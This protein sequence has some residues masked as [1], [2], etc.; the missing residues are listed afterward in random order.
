MKNVLKFVQLAFLAV[1]LGSFFLFVASV[2]SGCGDTEHFYTVKGESGV[3]GTNGA[4]GTNGING[5]QGPTGPINTSLIPILTSMP[6]NPQPGDEWFLY[7]PGHDFT[8]LSGTSS[9]DGGT[10][11]ITITVDAANAPTNNSIV[12]QKNCDGVINGIDYCANT[13]ISTISGLMGSMGIGYGN[14]NFNDIVAYLNG[15]PG[16][17]VTLSVE[18]DGD[19]VPTSN[20]MGVY[21]QSDAV[22]ESMT[23]YIVSAD[24]MLWSGDL[25]WQG[26]ANPPSGGK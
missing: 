3:D 20:Q 7:V 8:Q 16:F 2:L 4:A 26:P 22:N 17:T 11:S 25:G 9:I 14:H 18:A 19:L 13:P 10:G 24:G 6:T 21:L 23:L 5:V 1:L 15:L 12:F